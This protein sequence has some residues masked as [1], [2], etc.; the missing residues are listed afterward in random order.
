MEKI[1][2][3]CENGHIYRKGWNQV[4]DRKIGEV[5]D[6]N[7]AL[8][9]QY[10]K[11]RFADFQSKVNELAAKIEEASNKGSFLVKLKHLYDTLEQHDG[12]GDYET[13]QQQLQ[14]LISNISDEIEKN[15]LKNTEIKELLREELKVAV[16]EV[17]WKEATEKVLQIKDR[18]L[19]TGSV[20]QSRHGELESD[21]WDTIKE[22][23]ERKQSFY[24]DRKRLSEFY[25]KKYQE[26]VNEARQVQSSSG[27]MRDKLAELKERW[28]SN[29]PVP[30]EVYGPLYKAFHDAI[31]PR[32]N[33]EILTLESIQQEISKFQDSK[34]TPDIKMI[35]DLINKSR[36]IRTRNEDENNQL[37]FIQQQLMM[38]N[39][40]LFVDSLCRKR[41][42][43]FGQLSLIEQNTW[44]NKILRDLLER[45]KSNL[46]LYQLNQEKFNLNSPKL[47]EMMQQ[48]IVQQQQQI[49]IKER[50]LA[51]ITQKKSTTET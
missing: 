17:N 31:K 1:F 11:D 18:W 14:R 40:K 3:Y 51:Q 10:F 15:R 37:G 6:N 45:D 42:K 50:L 23:Y 41:H 34:N 35:N 48:K 44:R 33:P 2:G 49:V 38:I 13:I 27:N 46:A 29:G 36:K 12:I 43:G 21:F 19:K 25:A 26:L 24:E 30:E 28:K 8:S 39:E 5:R 47:N 7:E 16:E 20:D 9:V 32:F 22:F 4:P